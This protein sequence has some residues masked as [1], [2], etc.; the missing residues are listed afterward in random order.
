[1]PVDLHVT[2]SDILQGAGHVDDIFPYFL[3]HARQIFPHLECMDDLKKISDLRQPANWYPSARAINRKI[4]F[5]SGPTNSGKTYH[6]MERFMTAKS[7]VYC[8][9]LKLL[10]TEVY[11]KSNQ[12]VPNPSFKDDENILTLSVFLTVG[13]TLR[14]GHRRRKEI[15][16]TKWISLGTRLMHCRND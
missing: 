15:C 5:H 6:A 4:I 2:I 3:R 12:M 7:G 10:A 14:L 8:G 9:P 11:H 13:N 16:S 1:L